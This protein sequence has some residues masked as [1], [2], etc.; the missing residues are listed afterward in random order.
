M[1][2]LQ[3][4]CQARIKP[5]RT[6]EVT[7][8][9][10]GE[11]VRV[12]PLREGIKERG[13]DYRVPT[14]QDRISGFAQVVEYLGQCIDQRFELWA[15]TVYR[16]FHCDLDTALVGAMVGSPP[17]VAGTE[18]TIESFHLLCVSSQRLQSRLIW[19]SPSTITS[20]VTTEPPRQPRKT[21]YRFIGR[22]HTLSF[23]SGYDARYPA[24]SSKF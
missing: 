5:L 14:V 8:Y 22:P 6:Y 18:R 2:V 13:I 9:Q 24:P 19:H 12:H 10:V 15:E 17:I 7:H 11:K 21:W 1:I 4:V 3:P 23:S 20:I 16:L